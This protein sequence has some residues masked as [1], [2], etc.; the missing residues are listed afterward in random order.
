MKLAAYKGN[1]KAMLQYA[2]MLDNGQGV[3]MNKDE[4]QC[5]YRMAADKGSI[6]AR[7]YYNMSYE[8]SQRNFV[9]ATSRS[10][11]SWNEKKM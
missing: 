11:Q 5:Y 7:V 3:Q 6:D 4:A 10:T 1:K 2:L 8:E 9:I